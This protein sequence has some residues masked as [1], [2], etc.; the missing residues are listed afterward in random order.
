[1]TGR[2]TV[3]PFLE[4]LHCDPH[5]FKQGNEILYVQYFRNIGDRDRLSGKQNGTYHLQSLILSSLRLYFTAQTMSA[6]YHK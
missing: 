1:M 3:L 2:E 6:F 4:S 5:A